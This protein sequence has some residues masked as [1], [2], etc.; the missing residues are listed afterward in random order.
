MTAR[1]LWLH[2]RSVSNVFE[3]LGS[4][5]NDLTKALGWSLWKSPEFA[6][7]LVR[8]IV[9]DAR[10]P[11]DLRIRL[12][13][14]KEGDRGYTDV[15]IV[16]AGIHL[17][18]EAKLGWTVPEISQLLRYDRFRDPDAVNRLVSLSRLTGHQARAKLP[19]AL[20][21][22][23]G[24]VP[25]CHLSWSDARAAARAAL[26]KRPR[27]ATAPLLRD[28]LDYLKV[29]DNVQNLKSN[30]TCLIVLNSPTL[31]GYVETRQLYFHEQRPSDRFD[32]CPNYLAFAYGGYLRSIHHVESHE[33]IVPTN[34]GPGPSKLLTN[35]EM[36]DLQVSMDS[37]VFLLGSPIHPGSPVVVGKR[38][39]RTKR[40]CMLHTLLTRSSFAE[41]RRETERLERKLQGVDA[42]EESP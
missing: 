41:A 31:I 27:A 29:V 26:T 3:L 16:G 9:P 25:V 10:R 19:L 36:K 4:A 15:E 18:V 24:S 14:F 23:V 7:A 21:L 13:E 37:F 39:G 2:G 42:L 1:S 33:Y 40:W 5:E 28:F 38:P 20:E 32:K 34:E 35:E 17:I 11:L 22:S 30:Y 6:D 8:R 12:Q